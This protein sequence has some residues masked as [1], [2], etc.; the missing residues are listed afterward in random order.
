[1]ISPERPIEIPSTRISPSKFQPPQSQQQVQHAATSPP[2]H[3][4]KK[5]LGPSPENRLKAVS[6]ESLRSVSPGSD[7]VFYTDEADVIFEHQVHYGFQNVF[8]F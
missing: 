8:M 7:S 3:S 5:R 1:M 2:Q 6:T 4:Q